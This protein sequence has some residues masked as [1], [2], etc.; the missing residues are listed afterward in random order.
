MALSPASAAL[1]AASVELL[2]LLAR[3]LCSCWKECGWW[4]SCCCFC[5]S[6]CSSNAWEELWQAW[7]LPEPPTTS[8]CRWCSERVAG[9]VGAVRPLALLGMMMGFSFGM[10]CERDSGVA[11]VVVRAQ[12][13]LVPDG[14]ASVPVSGGEEC[15]AASLETRCASSE[16]VEAVMASCR[17]VRGGPGSEIV[18]LLLPPPPPF[19]AGAGV[20]LSFAMSTLPAPPPSCP[21]RGADNPASASSILPNRPTPP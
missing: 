20:K 7:L 3:S 17:A 18:S 21:S 9:D 13:V 11:V 14:D 8:S 1:N 16:H 5:H 19:F 2:L 10:R 6:C 15:R 4:P 12:L